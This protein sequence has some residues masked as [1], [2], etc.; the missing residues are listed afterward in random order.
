M[1]QNVE[2]KKALEAQLFNENTLAEKR[3]QRKDT[4]PRRRMMTMRK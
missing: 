4:K 2:E 3:Q 1:K